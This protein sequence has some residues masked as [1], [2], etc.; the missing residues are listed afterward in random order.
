MFSIKIFYK[1]RMIL[2]QSLK[3]KSSAWMGTLK[4]SVYIFF[5]QKKKEKKL[6]F[7]YVH[8]WVSAMCSVPTRPAEG[9]ESLKLELQVV[10]NHL[11]WVVGTELVSSGKGPSSHSHWAIS[12]ALFTLQMCA[13]GMDL[14]LPSSVMLITY[15]WSVCSLRTN[16]AYPGST[17]EHLFFQ[18]S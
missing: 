15:P 10:V 1:P 17:G 5:L 18:V 4:C 6:F 9:T 2:L 12:T 16:F 7:I 11:T 3:N 13:A 8:M 14:A